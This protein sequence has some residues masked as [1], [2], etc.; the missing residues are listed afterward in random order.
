MCVL[1]FLFFICLFVSLV[2]VGSFEV[3]SGSPASSKIQPTNMKKKRKAEHC[4]LAARGITSRI[5]LTQ[6]LHKVSALL[7]PT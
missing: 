2:S 6:F 5:G 7:L 4:A 1:F 3:T